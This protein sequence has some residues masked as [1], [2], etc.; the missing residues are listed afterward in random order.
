[1]QIGQ[2][3]GL[4]IG[5]ERE[6]TEMHIPMKGGIVVVRTDSGRLYTSIATASTEQWGQSYP[7]FR[8]ISQNVTFN[9]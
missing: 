6:A 4:K 3:E 5:V 7:Q 1:M 2:C 8:A 9:G